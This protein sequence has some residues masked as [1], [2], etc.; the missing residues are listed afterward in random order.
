MLNVNLKSE[1]TLDELPYNFKGRIVK[2]NH[3]G[4][5]KRHLMDLSLC[6]GAY[7]KCVDHGHKNG[8]RCYEICSSI[9][10]IRNADA[11]KIVINNIDKEEN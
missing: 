6:P 3:T 10:A 7:V 5:F 4:F 9:I 8:I 1:F 2:L 11:K